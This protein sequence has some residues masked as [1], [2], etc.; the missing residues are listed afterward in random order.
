MATVRID[1]PETGKLFWLERPVSLFSQSSYGEVSLRSPGWSA[2]KWNTKH[3]GTEAFVSTR[4]KGYLCG[5]V[6]GTK[7]AAHRV[8]WA[9][10]YGQWPSDQ[11]DHVNGDKTDNRLANLRLATASENGCNRAR[12]SSNTSGRKGVSWNRQNQKWQAYIKRGGKQVHL[13]YFADLNEA[14]AAYALAARRYYGA[15]ARAE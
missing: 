4:G 8:V 12:F 2:A 10:A 3:A 7:L 13:G 9:L 6:L 1:E 11:I 5:K 14:S 15:F